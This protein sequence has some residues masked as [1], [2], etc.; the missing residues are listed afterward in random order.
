MIH[1]YSAVSDIHQLVYFYIEKYHEPES[2][3]DQGTE[4]GRSG[5][6]MAKKIAENN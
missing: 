2:C 1:I 5:Y 3:H 6:D 4:S